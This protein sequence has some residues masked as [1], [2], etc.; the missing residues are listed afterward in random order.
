M[1]Y[2]ITLKDHKP[3]FPNNIE[4]ISINPA[5]SNLGK[6]SK[7]ILQKI[8]HKIRKSIGVL[9]WRGTPAV[10]LWFKDFPYK[11]RG[12]FLTFDVVHFYPFIS[13]KLLNDAITFAK[14]FVEISNDDSRN[15]HHCRKSLLFSRDSAWIKTNGSLLDIFYYGLL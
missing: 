8:N 10:I 7:Q 6:I 14:R 13:E 9:Q 15:I 1:L 2:I 5:K 12:I 4:C 3:N 11:E